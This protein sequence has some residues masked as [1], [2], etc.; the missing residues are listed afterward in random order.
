MALYRSVE[1]PD[2]GPVKLRR[3]RDALIDAEV[4]RETCNSYVRSRREDGPLGGL[5]RVLCTVSELAD[6]PAEADVPD[7]PPVVKA[8]AIAVERQLPPM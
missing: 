1:V 7:S 8:V 3:Y 2:F 6:T 4:N 5:T